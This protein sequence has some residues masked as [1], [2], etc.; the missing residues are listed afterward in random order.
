MATF[1]Q[2]IP[3]F[4]NS[5]CP[6]LVVEFQTTAELL[7]LDAVQ[8]YGQVKNFSHYVMSGNLLMS[9]NEEGFKWWVIGSVSD[10]SVIDLPIWNG[11]KFRAELPDGSHV[12][13]EKEVVSS[14]GDVLTLHDGTI[15]KNLRA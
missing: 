10:P 7:A 12:T 6:P 14:C 1:K 2:Y 9:V 13:L 11:W 4:M 3:N 15:A 8:C 5:A